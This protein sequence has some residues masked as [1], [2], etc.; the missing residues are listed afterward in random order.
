V[1]L[2]FDRIEIGCGELLPGAADGQAI[3]AARSE[4]GKL[5]VARG[6]VCHDPPASHT[7]VK[8]P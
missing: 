2:D 8:D 6:L 5:L 1:D 3:G 4:A 7:E